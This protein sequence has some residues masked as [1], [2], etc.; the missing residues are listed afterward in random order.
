MT[1]T[2]NNHKSLWMAVLFI[3][4]LTVGAWQIGE[5]QSKKQKREGQSAVAD[6]TFP[7]GD[8]K[9]KHEIKAAELEKAMK[10]LDAAMAKLNEEMGKLDF[11]KME[12]ELQSALKEIDAQKIETSVQKALAELNKEKVNE[13]VQEAL[14]KAQEELKKVDMEQLKVQMQQLKASLKDNAI[15]QTEFKSQFEQAM[16]Q[17]KDGMLKAKKEMKLIQEF[18][19]ALHNDGLIVKNKP[20]TVEL[21][22]GALYING[23]KQN[24]TVKNKYQKYLEGRKDNFSI[25]NDGQPAKEGK[26]E[27]IK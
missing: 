24:E 19:D 11:T 13:H 1:T 9:N 4:T 26:G 27:E 18:I 21:K 6:T 23:E 7:S 25:K 14:A 8:L 22:D 5:A 10:H 16:K 20:Y 12:R 17:A 15:N 3:L 2:K